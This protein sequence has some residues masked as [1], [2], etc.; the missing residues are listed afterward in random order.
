VRAKANSLR[1]ASQ[2]RTGVIWAAGIALLTVSSFCVVVMAGTLVLYPG[3]QLDQQ[4]ERNRL[5]PAK[6]ELK[7]YLTS[8]SDAATEQTVL[9]LKPGL[10]DIH[11]QSS[12]G[13]INTALPPA[14]CVGA[15]SDQQRQVMLDNINSRCTDVQSRKVGATWVVDMTCT[16]GRVTLTKHTV[17]SLTGDNFREENTAPQGTMTSEGKWLSACKPGQT[18]TLFK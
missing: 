14:V 17:T 15:M 16:T 6:M 8:D 18:P 13:G 1:P 7:R 12:A 4:F 9:P 10:W 11:S 3:A 2:T 5:S